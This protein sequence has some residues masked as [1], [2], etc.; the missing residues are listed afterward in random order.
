MARIAKFKVGEVVR[1]GAEDKTPFP[2]P[3][4]YLRRGRLVMITDIKVSREKGVIL[5]S[6]ANRWCKPVVW[7]EA[8]WFRKRSERDRRRGGGRV[9]K[10]N[11]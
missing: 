1:L 9:A 3:Y 7:L 5:Y 10:G 2:V 4:D 8:K 6:I 11:D